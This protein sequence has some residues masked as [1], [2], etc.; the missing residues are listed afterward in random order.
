MKVGLGLAG[1][2][3]AACA[4]PAATPLPEQPVPVGAGAQAIEI[5]AAPVPLNPRDPRQTRVGELTYAGGVALTARGT[6]RLGGLSGMDIRWR[7]NGRTFLAVTDQGDLIEADIV[8]DAAGRV[9]GLNNAT[10]RPLLDEQGRPVAR[11]E[12]A[13][14]EGLV[15]FPGDDF[16]VSFERGHR[17]WVYDR[18][19][20]PARSFPWAAGVPTNLGDNEGLEALAHPPASMPTTVVLGAEDGRT[21]QCAE[22]TCRPAAP[23][24]LQAGFSLTGMDA[25]HRELAF[26]VFRAFDPLRGFRWMIGWSPDLLRG[27]PFRPLAAFEPPL[28]TDNFEAIAAAPWRDGWRIYVASDDNFRREQRTLLLA[29][30]WKPPPGAACP[31]E[32]GTP[33]PRCEAPKKAGVSAG[34]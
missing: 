17:V 5:V 18:P 13:D 21:W 26:A 1:L 28:V 33:Q 29:F 31:P 34:P 2:L 14:A 22:R 7:E 24:R 15:A 6:S 27:E 11:K 25:P 9:T 16:A 8:L 10:I 3:L 19:G 12:A 4:A 20:A 32:G 23:A 30:D